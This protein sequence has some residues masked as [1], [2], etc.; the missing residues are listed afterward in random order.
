MIRPYRLGVLTGDG[1]GPEIVPAALE[2]LRAGL[3]TEPSLDVELVPL[4]MGADA[5]A[6]H[7]AMVP[8]VTL[9]GLRTCDGWIMG[10]HDNASYAD[11]D[12]GQG[13]PNRV[14]RTTFGLRAN[15]RPARQ[16][17]GVPSRGAPM[18]VLVVRENTEGLYS[19]RNLHVGHGEL[20]PTPDVALTVGVFTRAAIREVVE[21]AF[22]SAAT[23]RGHLTV[24]HKAN[25]LARSTGMFLEVC[26][27]LAPGHPGVTVDEVLVDAAAAL[28]VRDPGRFDVMVTENLFGDVLSDLAVELSGSLGLGASLNVG[29]GT[30]MAQAAHG[31][32]PDIAGRGVANPTG[33]VLSVAMLLRWLGQRH[34]DGAPGRV[35]DRIEDAVHD[36]LARGP[37]TPDLGGTAT[38]DAFA[39]TV[40]DACN[41]DQPTRAPSSS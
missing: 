15:L 11:R 14:L 32:A 41:P 1:I 29:T 25:V 20:L 13:T 5:I 36:V 39:A 12:R 2:V 10:P 18:D 17:P 34:D 22:R 8:D 9:E 27:E 33:L 31:A 4:P 40:A 38:T 19:D 37:R 35:A 21:L 28:L 23:R 16:L 26:E 30:A 24:V 7:G 6:D 3:A